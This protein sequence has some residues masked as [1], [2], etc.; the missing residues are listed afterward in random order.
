MRTWIA[1]PGLFV[2]LTTTTYPATHRKGAG[3]QRSFIVIHDMRL[4]LC[5]PAGRF[6]RSET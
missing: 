6:E 2:G 1:R 4:L 3:T 5:V